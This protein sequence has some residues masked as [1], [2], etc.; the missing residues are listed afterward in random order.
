MSIG[1][2]CRNIRPAATDLRRLSP[3]LNSCSTNASVRIGAHTDNYII[4]NISHANHCYNHD[5]KAV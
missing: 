4:Y 1:A 3:W 2:L 5:M